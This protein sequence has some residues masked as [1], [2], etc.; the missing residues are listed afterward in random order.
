MKIVQPG[1]RS[2]PDIYTNAHSRYAL[3]A[4]LLD[5]RHDNPQFDF[6]F[7][8]RFALAR[9]NREKAAELALICYGNAHPMFERYSKLHGLDTAVAFQTADKS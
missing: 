5:Y 9:R 8:N 3:R 4:S 2:R 7:S 1:A 6:I